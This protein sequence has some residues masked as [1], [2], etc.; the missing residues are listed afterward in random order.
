M[1]IIHHAHLALIRYRSMIIEIF[2]G[3]VKSAVFIWLMI[4]FSYWFQK[5]VQ[6]L[7]S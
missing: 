2:I 6:F 5:L 4:V 7:L 1:S 3:L